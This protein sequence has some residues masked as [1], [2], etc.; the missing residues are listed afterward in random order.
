MATDSCQSTTIPSQQ[1]VS[2]TTE[3]MLEVLDPKAERKESVQKEQFCTREIS[4]IT[5]L[6]I[7]L[8][9]QTWYSGASRYSRI[10]LRKELESKAVLTEEQWNALHNSFATFCEQDVSILALEWHCVCMF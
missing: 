5:L 8:S 3:I 10:S 2:E 6:G 4:V 7:P 1:R 9:E